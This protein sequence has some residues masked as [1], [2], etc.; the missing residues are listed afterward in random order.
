MNNMKIADRLRNNLAPKGTAN[1]STLC[2]SDR[3]VDYDFVLKCIDDLEKIE[4]NAVLGIEPT[5]LE[6]LAYMLLC[7]SAYI[8][9]KEYK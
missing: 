8:D 9:L 2:L 5:N 1:I 6:K 3:F 7:N 4:I